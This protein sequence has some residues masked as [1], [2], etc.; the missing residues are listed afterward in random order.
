MT[1]SPE[2]RRDLLL[3]ASRKARE[4]G[5]IIEASCLA[6]DARLVCYHWDLPV[7]VGGPA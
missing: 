6:R 7:P 5:K 2:R 1:T 4:K 3:E